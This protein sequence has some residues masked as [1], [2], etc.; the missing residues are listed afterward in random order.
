M[1]GIIDGLGAVLLPK[2][3]GVKGGKGFTPTF[4]PRSA[5]MTAPQYRDHLTDLYSSRQS[6]DSRSLMAILANMDPDV[7]AAMTAFLSI[8]GSVDPVVYAYNEKDEIDPEGITL[9]QQLL[10]LLT[11]TNDYTIGY[12]AKP[13]VDAL[14]NDHRY[15]TLLRGGTACE[16]V[17]DKTYVPNELRLVDP[18]SLEWEQRQNGVYSPIQRPA[19]SNVPIDLNI[20][21]FFTS[22]FHQSPLD[23]YTY[24]TFVSA[25]NTIASRQQ[26]INELYRIMKIVGYPRV[27]IEVMEDMLATAAPPSMRTDPVKM[28]AFVENELGRI[29]ATISTLGSADAFV[30]TS[31]VKATIINDKNPSAG[32]QIDNVIEVLNA[33]NQAALKV[34]PSV[35]GKGNNGQ[36]ASTEARLFALN[37]DALNR[38]VAGL[39]TK[40]LTLGARLSGYAGRIEVVFPPVEL[41]PA[42]EL[43]PQK[44]MRASRLKTDLSLGIITDIEYS[45]EMYGRPPLPGAPPLS[46]TNF[47]DAKEE[48]VTM[49]TDDVSSNTDSLGRSLSG[50]GGNGVAKDN[51]AK[52]GNTKAKPAGKL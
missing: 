21:T 43:E 11:T 32:I 5:T 18:V 49:K 39:F 42:L 44:T 7:S 3:K 51:A 10:A 31:A 22:N 47:L 16:L 23:L 35:V 40:A 41:R 34:M 1:A 2:G 20:P 9:G 4:N 37:A 17:L 24:S 26:V 48:E 52:S 46:G 15:L 8:A 25:I 36:V 50:E 19:N 12:S 33:Q 27:D 14:C 30:H 28:R 29:R 45:M 6:S 13:T 38:S